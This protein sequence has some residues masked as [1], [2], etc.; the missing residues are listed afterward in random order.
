M[1]SRLE[2]AVAAEVLAEAARKRLSHKEIQS[3]AAIN[4]RSW[5]RYF[6][7]QVRPIPVTD[8]FG[9]AEAL[10][11]SPSELLRRAEARIAADLSE[12][13]RAQ[14]EQAKAHVKKSG[15][16][17]RTMPRRDKPA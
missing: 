17:D 9:V 8:L 13:A 4:P 5:G 11:V 14:V 15:V 3:R 2:A 6:V 16:A 7:Q 10:G 1:S 12:E